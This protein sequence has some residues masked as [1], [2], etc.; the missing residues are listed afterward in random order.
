[1]TGKPDSTDIL[2][3]SAVAASKPCIRFQTTEYQATR[4]LHTRLK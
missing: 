2:E 3:E 1:M 4:G